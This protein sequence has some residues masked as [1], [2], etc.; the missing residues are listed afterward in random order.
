MFIAT[1]CEAVCE[2]MTT[3]WCPLSKMG[4]DWRLLESEEVIAVRQTEAVAASSQ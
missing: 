1:K 4:L 3:R 2:Q